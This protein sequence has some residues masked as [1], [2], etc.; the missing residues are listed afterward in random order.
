MY[1]NE[2][3]AAATATWLS[4][5]ISLSAYEGGRGAC[6]VAHLEPVPSERFPAE[7]IHADLP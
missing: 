6:F 4:A 2:R 3:R 5:H 7:D 1:V